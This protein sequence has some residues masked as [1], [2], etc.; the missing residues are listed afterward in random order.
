MTQNDDTVGVPVD[1][2]WGGTPVLGAWTNL[3]G[4]YDAATGIARLYVDGRL[5]GQGT[6]TSVWK[7]AGNLQIGRAKW[8][9]ILANHL[10]GAIDDV[11][12]YN[13]VLGNGVQD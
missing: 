10:L 13:R 11:R 6:H 3:I 5:V 7:A 2:V 4:T 8:T 12:V 1:T 9:N